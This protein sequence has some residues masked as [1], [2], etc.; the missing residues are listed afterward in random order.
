MM[1]R[2]LLSLATQDV[3]QLQQSPL[4]A[5][6]PSPLRPHPTPPT[7]QKNPPRFGDTGRMCN[8]D[9]PRRLHRPLG[10]STPATREGGGFIRGASPVFAVSAWSC[11]CN[12]QTPSQRLFQHPPRA[13]CLEGQRRTSGE[14]L[15]SPPPPPLHPRTGLLTYRFSPSWLYLFVLR[16]QQEE[17][18]REQSGTSSWPPRTTSSASP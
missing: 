15:R 14:L 12:K 8:D 5:R 17:D 16:K 4:S 1:G 3:I 10:D 7:N 2:P 6:A 18:E 9:A 11:L 13:A